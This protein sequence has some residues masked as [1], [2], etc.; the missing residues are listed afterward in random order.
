MWLLNHHSSHAVSVTPTP[1]K[2]WT[3]RRFHDC[4]G[5]DMSF[6]QTTTIQDCMRICEPKA[7]CMAVVFVETWINSG[8]NNCY[9]KKIG[10]C[11]PVE[12]NRPLAIETAIKGNSMHNIYIFDHF[13][14]LFLYKCKCIIQIQQ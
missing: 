12:D 13:Y 10:D 7:D 2:Y 9:P 3:I 6:H 1:S 8:W 14:F 11:K 4:K 5:K